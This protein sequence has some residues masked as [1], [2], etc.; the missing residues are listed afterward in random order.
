[1]SAECSVEIT[2]TSVHAS[3]AMDYIVIGRDRG[4]DLVRAVV[5]GVLLPK[6][7]VAGETWRILGIERE[8]QVYGRQ[9]HASTALPLPPTGD[10]IVRLLAVDPRF[11]GVGWATARLLWTHFGSELY[12][13]LE[14]G[15]AAALA[16]VCG[17]ERAAVIAAEFGS[18]SDDLHVFRE[19]DKYGVSPRT[20]GA[21]A[22]I[23][24]RGAVSRI[25]VN[26]YALSL[27]ESWKTIDLRALRIGV[28]ENDAR[29]LVAGV[30]EALSKAVRS[31][32]MLLSLK[33]T[34]RATRSLL[35]ARSDV[36]RALNL[37]VQSGAVVSSDRKTFQLRGCEFMERELERQ[38][39]ERSRIVVEAD[40]RRVGAA[41]SHLEE[42]A[43]I[44]LTH[45]QREAVF[46]AAST[47]VSVLSGGAGTGKTAVLRAIVEAE[48]EAAAATP[49]LLLVALAGRAARRMS[50]VTK[51]E[52]WTLARLRTAVDL[53]MTM[54]DG[55][56]VF[57]EASML[58]TPSIYR[59]LSGMGDRVRLLFVG[60]GGQ[61]PPIGAGLPFQKLLSSA[62]VP[63]VHLDVI[64]R[65]A[66][67]TGI[68]NVAAS[69]RRGVCPEFSPYRFSVP[70][71]PGVHLAPC[72]SDE[73][74]ST[75]RRVFRS[76]AGAPP[77]SG[78]W[79]R[80]QD[81]DIQILCP[82]NSGD[83]GARTLSRDIEREYMVHQQPIES[84]GIRVGSRL[85]W[86]KNDC[87]KAPLLDGGK[88]IHDP[89]T[90]EPKFSGF[91]NGSLGVPTIVDGKCRLEL[92][93]G[94]ADFIGVADLERLTLGWA[95]TIHKAQG[96]SFNSVIVPVVDSQ[97]LDRSMLYTAVTRAV[98]T[99]VIIGDPDIIRRAIES[100]PRTRYRECGLDFGATA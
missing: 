61:L 6:T 58:D 62:A 26:P 79:R 77:E 73:I 43:G 33:D 17:P 15:D 41:I 27:L 32:H 59:A 48:P 31:G 92:D 64:H 81:R 40:G 35:G 2:V 10:G 63:N 36:R 68:P 4:P 88:P 18:L 74:A 65:Q 54:E 93:D 42:T 28:L 12:D 69:I 83:A 55:L 7:P 66:E 8:H 90:G 82:T 78:G 53:G 87:H 96:S 21:A 1:M 13:V 38:I 84:W 70:D 16:P 72:R 47:G 29:R 100:E 98:Q 95:I 67:Q 22:R 23:W 60:D 56:L 19:L 76:L 45:R 86:L 49:T 75:V 39:A 57:D 25:K 11:T 50:L 37:A 24:G 9:I 20:A 94:S 71:Q 85:M 14:A 34:M 44:K 99:A 5:A 80:L 91:F 52:A 89:R 51:R 30:E 3:R 97:L 46:M